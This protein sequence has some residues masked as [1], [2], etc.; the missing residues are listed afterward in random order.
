[1]INKIKHDLQLS[2]IDPE[3]GGFGKVFPEVMIISEGNIITEGNISPNPPNGG[4]IND[5]LY[6]KTKMLMQNIKNSFQ[7]T[8]PIFYLD[9]PRFLRLFANL[10]RVGSLE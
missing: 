6:R 3:R 2:F 9:F 4:S 5:I 1:M 10:R 8:L 7:R